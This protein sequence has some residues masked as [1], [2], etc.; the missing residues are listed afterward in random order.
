MELLLHI[1]E[2]HICT[3]RAVDNWD[4]GSKESLGHNPITV[5]QPERSQHHEWYKYCAIEKNGKDKLDFSLKRIFTVGNCCSSGWQTKL[6]GWKQ[7]G[8]GVMANTVC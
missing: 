7:Y 6:V 2:V 8:T 3:D 5:E 1:D 4:A